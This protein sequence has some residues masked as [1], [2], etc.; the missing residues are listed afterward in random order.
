MRPRFEEACPWE[1]VSRACA[2]GFP[3]PG[4]GTSPDP[5]FKVVAF[6]VLTDYFPGIYVTLLY[7]LVAFL[8]KRK[9]WEM[10]RPMEG[11]DREIEGRLTAHFFFFFFSILFIYS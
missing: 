4:G 9:K 8:K 11:K 3:G 10:G 5:H 1:R 7:I 2:S 6:T